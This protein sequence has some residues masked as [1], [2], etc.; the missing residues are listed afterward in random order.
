[1]LVLVTGASGK[2]G[3]E[4]VAALRKAGHRT[5]SWDLRPTAEAPAVVVDCADF[6]HVIG[7]LSGVDPAGVRPDAIVHLAAIPGPGSAPDHV[8]FQTNTQS[9]YNIFSAAARLGIDRVVW[10]SSETILGLP[11][12]S[13]PDFAPLDESHPDRPEWTYSLTKAAGELMA[14][15]FVRWRPRMSI[16]SLRFSNVFTAADYARLPAIQGKPDG[17]KMNLWGYVDARDAGEACRLA[18]EADFTG[19]ETM[20]IAAADTLVPEPSKSLM[21]RIFPDTPIR[22]DLAGNVSLLSSEKARRV[23]G[24]QPRHSWREMVG[25]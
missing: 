13:P 16:A 19:H 8:V 17:R 6:G 24:Y 11:F 7:A 21:A 20:I 1:M 3:R 9:T 23:I 14:R 4:A 10:A 5:L 25:G 15:N 22:G 18:V 12:D 2:L